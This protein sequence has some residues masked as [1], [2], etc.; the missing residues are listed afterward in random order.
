MK[1]TTSR[2]PLYVKYGEL[3]FSIDGK[4]L[5]LNVYKNIDR[6]YCD[7]VCAEQ[8]IEHKDKKGRVTLEWEKVSSHAQNHMLDVETNNALA[9]EILG[10][11]YL[12]EEKDEEDFEQD[13]EAEKQE[14]WFGN[15]GDDW[16]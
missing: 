3:H 15:I 4:D 16:L 5:K 6:R 12:Q 11:R 1:T 2:T 7:Q 14:N 8:K 13:Q 9:A 10:V